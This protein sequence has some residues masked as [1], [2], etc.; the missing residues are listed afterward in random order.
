M[1]MVE[2]KTSFSTQHEV[3]PW[4]YCDDKDCK[5]QHF[6]CRQRECFFESDSLSDVAQHVIENQFMVS[7]IK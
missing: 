6:G 5:T 1:E 7:N 2:N 3:R 4:Q